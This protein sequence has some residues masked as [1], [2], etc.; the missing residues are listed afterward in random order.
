LVL[1][2]CLAAADSGDVLKVL[3]TEGA[4]SPIGPYSQGG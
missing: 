3:F 2:L 4:S 1:V